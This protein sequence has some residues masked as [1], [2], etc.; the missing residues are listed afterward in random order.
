[1]GYLEAC[2]VLQSCCAGSSC[3]AKDAVAKAL[4]CILQAETRA[5]Q[6]Q[7]FHSHNQPGCIGLAKAF[8]AA[9]LMDWPHLGGAHDLDLLRSCGRLR[10]ASQVLQSGCMDSSCTAKDAMAKAFGSILQAEMRAG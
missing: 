9:C 7:A 5:G 4:G 1:M 8:T 6:G 3:T 10:H 2:K